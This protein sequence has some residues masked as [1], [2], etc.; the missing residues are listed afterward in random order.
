LLI[1][2]DVTHI[3]NLHCSLMIA[4]FCYG[5]FVLCYSYLKLYTT[6]PL[7][8]LATFMGPGPSQDDSRDLKKEIEALIIHLLCFKHKM[9]NVVW[10]RGTSGLEGKFQSGSEVGMELLMYICTDAVL[11]YFSCDWE[12]SFLSIWSH[13][14]LATPIYVFYVYVQFFC[15]YHFLLIMSH[16]H[17]LR[18]FWGG[19]GGGV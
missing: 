3:L 7:S 18:L 15:L 1:V 14:G 19:G 8:K 16:L 4:V 12:K 2:I 9:K 10:T 6:L 13:C 11:Y 17:M 5:L